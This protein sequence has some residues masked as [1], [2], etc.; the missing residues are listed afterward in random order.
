MN[1]ISNFINNKYNLE[2]QTPVITEKHFFDLYKQETNYIGIPWAAFIDN[3]FT[4]KINNVELIF[5]QLKLLVENEKKKKKYTK[6]FTCCQHI[7]YYQLLEIWKLIGINV[8]FLSHKV[9][10]I[11]K[12][13]SIKFYACPL[14]AAN[15]EDPLRN[16]IYLN[17]KANLINKKGNMLL[18]FKELIV[19]LI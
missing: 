1:E 18:D 8:V 16:K 19:N 10:L 3:K 12:S 6:I 14:Y 15:I 17:N 2:W 13:N 11:D 5:D 9:N 4:K 7:H